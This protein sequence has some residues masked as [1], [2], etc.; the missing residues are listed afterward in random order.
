M[1]E[2]NEEFLENALENENYLKWREIHTRMFG[3]IFS[4]AFSDNS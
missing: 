3:E 1:E 2:Y 4:S